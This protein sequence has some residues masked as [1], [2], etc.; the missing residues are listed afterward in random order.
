MNPISIP[1]IAMAT[2]V[3]YVGFY[4]FLI[5]RRRKENRENLTFAL[6]CFSVGLYAFCCAGLYNVSSPEVGVEWQRLQGSVLAILGIFLLWFIHDYTGHT[7]KKIAIGFTVYYIFA[8]LTGLLIRSD[9]TWSS[10]PS[11][12]EAWLPFGYNITYNEMAPGILI[13]FQGLVGLIYFIYIITVGIRFYRSGNKKKGVPL[14]IAMAILCA[15]LMNDTFISNGFYNFIYLLEYSYIGM[16]L[17]FTFFLTTK[18]ITAGEIKA[19]L[20]KSE[21]SYRLIAENV[22]DVIWT[23]DMNYKLTYVS[24]SIYQ[25]RGYTVKETMEQPINEMVLP[26][27]IEK[28]LNIYAE[29]LN[30]IESG[31]PEGW[32][33]YIFEIEQY[34]KDGTII[35]IS[36]N[37]RILMGSDKQPMSI[38]GV[39]R[40]ITD[41]VLAESTVKESE[42]KYRQIY[43]NIVDVYYEA[44]IDGTILEVSPS[45]EKLSQYKREELIGK[46]LYDLYTNPSE[47][48]D[49]IEVLLKKGNA[50]DYEISLSDKNGQ[51]HVCSLNVEF[52]IDDKDNPEKI[53]GVCRDISD[54]KHAEDEKI[55][56]QRIAGEHEKMA[57]V[58]QVAGKMAH[59]FNNILGII[60][61]NSELALIDCPD[62]QTKKILELIYNQT[63]R[64]KNLTRNLVAFAKDQEPKQ[65]FFSIDEKMDLVLNLLKKDLEGINVMRRYTHGIPDLL[66]DSGMIEHAMVNL[67]QN[68]IHALSL[69]ERPEI[70]VHTY[71]QG[72]LVFI[73]IE[74]N[75][76]GIPPDFLGEIYEPSFTLKGS[77]DKTGMYKPDIKGTGYGMSNVKKYIEQHKGSISIHSELQK[78]TKVTINLPVI[79]KELTNEEI[80]KVKKEKSSFEKYILIVEDEQ[81]ISDVQYKIL[82]HKSCNHKVDIASNGQVALDLM[83]RNEYDLI[84]LDY[85]L[86]GK[87]N[88]MD[89]YH[90]VREKNKNIPIL[91][92]SGNIEFLESIKD[93]KKKDLYIDHLS[94]PCKNVDYL[95][96][97]NQLF[98]N[99]VI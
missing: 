17:V 44:A 26:E 65:E 59:D 37:A 21:E 94:K 32:E 56:A 10:V 63:I 83:N 40:D 34:C 50:T 91:F 13:S 16:I 22:S 28:T 25:L 51:Q 82:T 2:L 57:L 68:S 70:I 4:H 11:I 52:I 97:I 42:K 58:G 77:K 90:H 69:T 30:L 7:N 33:P 87:F 14:L 96:G 23:M 29:K 74:D 18:V 48:D 72:R 43:D 6:T 35:W 12:K 8:A 24:P 66:A 27:S 41:R 89:V 95:N 71:H 73:E 81:D 64:G 75:G 54:R 92:I 60:M 15:G 31:D 9:L 67:V 47:R 62:D 98:E 1:P 93:L 53:I 20:I 49:L 5:Y 84:S 80:Q 88:G 78:G 45:I 76:C 86:P 39:T 55:K 19:A 85:V 61:G 38:L 79:K 3:F 36:N 99:T 46:S